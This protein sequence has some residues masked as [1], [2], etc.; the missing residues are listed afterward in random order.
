MVGNDLKEIHVN[1]HSQYN[2]NNIINDKDLVLEN[3]KIEKK[4]SYEDAITYYV[5]Y[6]TL[7]GIKPLYFTFHKQ[8]G[9]LKKRWV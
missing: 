8:I 6:E 2:S 3:I 7:D 1:D 9:L 5:G 4:K